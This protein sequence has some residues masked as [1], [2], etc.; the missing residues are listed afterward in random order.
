MD[1]VILLDLLC[2]L[3]KIYF[4]VFLTTQR[5]I[6]HWKCLGVS[7]SSSTLPRSLLT[8]SARVLK[9]SSGWD[10]S[11]ASL[12]LF[13]IG[14]TLYLGQTDNLAHYSLMTKER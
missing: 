1:N 11:E 5:Y 2:P 10:N 8:V 9:L 14:A 13:L 6:Q 4:D 7:A 3:K 12:F